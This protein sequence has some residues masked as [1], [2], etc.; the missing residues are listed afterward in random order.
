MEAFYRPAVSMY[1]IGGDWYDV[2]EHHDGR[3]TVTVGDIGGKGVTAAA[4]M[5]RLSKAL[6]IYAAEGYAPGELSGSGR[7]G[8]A[9]RDAA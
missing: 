5:V 2:L 9:R 8:H 7:C 4:E 3:V 1:E 6:R